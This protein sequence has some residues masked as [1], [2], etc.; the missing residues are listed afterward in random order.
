MATPSPDAASLARVFGDAAVSDDAVE[1]MERHAK[2]NEFLLTAIR[3]NDSR[4][5]KRALEADADV[6]HAGGKPLQEAATARNFLFMK[7]LVVNGADIQHA[8]EGLKAEQAAIQRKKKYD[9]WGDSD[10]YTFKNKF[11]KA[12]WSEI[13][14]LA[15]TLEDYQKKFI[16]EIMPM[17]SMRLQHETLREI[18]AI[19]KELYE[20]NH[21]V[22]VNKPRIRAP[23]V[24][25]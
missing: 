3:T 21:G 4:L 18:R 22:P 16:A 13:S 19:K 15:K 5:F 14:T 6:N 20:A 23:K 8:V 25:D 1:G 17:E 24:Y 11:E 10:G 2:L 9:Q 7:D 12:R